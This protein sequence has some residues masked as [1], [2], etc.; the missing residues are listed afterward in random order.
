ME[1]TTRDSEEGV[2]HCLRL[3]Y[4]DIVAM[5]KKNFGLPGEP[6]ELGG[7]CPGYSI[8]PEW[9][10]CSIDVPSHGA[11]DLGFSFNWTEGKLEKLGKTEL[12]VVNCPL[13]GKHID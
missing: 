4:N 9:Y 2:R 6:A 7:F 3:S 1:H 13:C 8:Q 5:V 10:G 11:G 12:V